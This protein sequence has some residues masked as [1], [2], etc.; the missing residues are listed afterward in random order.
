M[1]LYTYSLAS[2]H[3]WSV[4]KDANSQYLDR[5]DIGGV[6]VSTGLGLGENH[7]KKMQKE[8]KTKTDAVD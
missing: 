3:F 1:R 8:K 5:R 7:K 4:N 6:E 2:I